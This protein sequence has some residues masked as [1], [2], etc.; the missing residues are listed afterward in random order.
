MMELA[1]LISR[2][3]RVVAAVLAVYWMMHEVALASNGASYLELK[4]RDSFTNV[5]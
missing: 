1:S 5:I 3:S 2:R 4:C